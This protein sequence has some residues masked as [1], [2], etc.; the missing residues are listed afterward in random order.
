[1]LLEL[2]VAVC[3]D[4]IAVTLNRPSARMRSKGY[5]SWVCLCVCVSVTRNLTSRAS[6]Q[7]ENDI[8]Y[9]TGCEAQSNQV[10]F[11]E[12]TPLQRY[13]ASCIVWLS[14]QSAIL[15]TT[16]VHFS[17]Y[18]MWCEQGLW[19]TNYCSCLQAKFVQNVMLF[20]PGTIANHTSCSIFVCHVIIIAP[21]TKPIE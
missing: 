5:G 18:Y 15:E 2:F 19:I 9:S 4:F 17:V 6:F 12:T 3:H 21:L 11:S 8:T 10:D 13:T 14:V 16:H 1:M 20:E 7:P